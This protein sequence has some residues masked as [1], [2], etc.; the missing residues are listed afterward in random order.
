MT[1]M[2]D[3]LVEFVKVLRTAD[4]KVSP[5]ETLDAME[6]LDIVGIKNR[7]LLK[8][9]LSMVLSKTPEE[10]ETFNTSFDR[11]FSF[12]KFSSE[13]NAGEPDEDTPQDDG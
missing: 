6:A 2:H 10:K 1:E 3:T 12:N 13:N 7:A 4:V 8:N 9:S 5:A 11:F